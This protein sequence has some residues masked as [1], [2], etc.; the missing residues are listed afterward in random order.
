MNTLYMIP[1]H[2]DEIQEAIENGAN[3]YCKW[4]DEFYDGGCVCP[5]CESD[6]TVNELEY[7]FDIA[8]EAHEV[9]MGWV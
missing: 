9:K 5:E 1:R 2:I 7:Y 4:C 6:D 8:V 3:H